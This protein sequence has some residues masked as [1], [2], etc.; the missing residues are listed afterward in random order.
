MYDHCLKTYTQTVVNSLV[1]HNVIG[2]NS[3]TEMMLFICVCEVFVL[4][5]SMKRRDSSSCG[6]VQGD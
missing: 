1:W 6:S 2:A 5:S 3:G 4:C